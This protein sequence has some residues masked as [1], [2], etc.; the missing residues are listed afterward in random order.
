MRSGVQKFR[1][2]WGWMSPGWAAAALP[3]QET[4]QH[5]PVRSGSSSSM[6]IA[7]ILGHYALDFVWAFKGEVSVSPSPAGLRQLSF[8]AF[9]AKCSGGSFSQYWTPGLGNLTWGK[10]P[11]LLWE[12]LCSIIILQPPI[13]LHLGG[14]RFNYFTSLLLLPVM[15]WFL[16]YVGEDL[17][18]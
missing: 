18:W 2:S 15:L 12:N 8:T 1:S 3:L 7:F 5:P 6:F 17:F 4:L 9:K 16:L 10:Q 11:L 13:H 14:M